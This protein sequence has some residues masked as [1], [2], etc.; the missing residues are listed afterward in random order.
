MNARPWQT[1][2]E[3]FVL[4][5]KLDQACLKVLTAFPRLDEE[6]GAAPAS[7][8]ERTPDFAEVENSSISLLE[9]LPARIAAAVAEEVDR[10]QAEMFARRWRAV[11]DFI[12]SLGSNLGEA[13][14]YLAGLTHRAEEILL[15]PPP[16]VLRIRAIT[17]F[18]YSQAG[19]LHYAHE[20]RKDRSPVRPLAALHDSMRWQKISRG[21]FHGRLAGLTA[22]G[23]V[24]VNILKVERAKALV[25]ARDCRTS[26]N[27]HDFE[28]FAHREEAL[29]AISG[30]FFLY[31][32]TDIEEPAAQFDPVGLLVHKGKV[33]NPPTFFR[34][35]LVVDGL[36][37][38][39]IVRLGLKGVVIRLSDGKSIRISAVNKAGRT[40]HEPVAFTRAGNDD[41]PPHPA[42][43]LTFVRDTLVKVDCE[44][45]VPIPVNGFV[46]TL[47]DRHE[48]EAFSEVLRPGQRVE[49]RLPKIHGMA[50]VREAMAGGPML[51][52][53][54]RVSVDLQREDFAG[55]APPVTFSTDETFDQNLLPRLAVGTTPDHHL[56]FAAV[57]GRNFDRALGLTL[58]RTARLM[59][60]LGCSNALN[61]DGG[62]SKRM[63]VSGKTVDLPSTEVVADSADATEVRPVHTAILVHPK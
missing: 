34:G 1:S 56:I 8:V 30:G 43:C 51:V 40:R 36:T 32:E 20:A 5:N 63:V 26:G 49:F 7:Q 41:T 2:C 38:S 18:Y 13:R 27:G 31:S 9:S 46:V 10:P 28:A 16:R 62:A 14:V 44:G 48:W 59:R 6:D 15:A 37:H 21:V 24:N 25:T 52:E 33:L 3:Q 53:N 42:K 58:H 60:L 57:D 4:A 61:L 17:D 19:I 47:P 50:R 11:A 12:R 23:P 35:A 55:G 54:D 45:P 22:R 29:A 39:H